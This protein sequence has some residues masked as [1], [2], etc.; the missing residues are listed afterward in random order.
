MRLVTVSVL[1]IVVSLVLIMSIATD[2][3]VSDYVHPHSYFGILLVGAV[4]TGLASV[5]VD[6]DVPGFDRRLN[7]GL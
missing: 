1:Y 6:V 4:I 2:I 5:V 3:F 7:S